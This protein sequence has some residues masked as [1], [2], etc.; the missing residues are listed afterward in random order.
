MNLGRNLLFVVSLIVLAFAFGCDGGSKPGKPS[1]S[2]EVEKLSEQKTELQSRMEQMR[3]ENE[4]LKKEVETLSSLPGDKRAEAIYHLKAVRISGYS[5][6]FNENKAAGSPEKKLV[7]YVQPEDETGD[8]IKA[9]GAVEIQLWDLNKKES[10]AMLGQ[11]RIEPNE[12][13]KLWLQ[14]MMA[15]GYRFS[16]DVTKL[17]DKFDKPL[18]IRM[19]FTDYLSGRVFTEEHIIRPPKPA[20]KQ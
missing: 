13:K 2:Q 18:T 12:L 1:L 14:T 5:N 3:G 4:Q 11:W 10:D 15:T 16:F 7:V 19:T 9:A 20:G 17:V 6:I 8:V